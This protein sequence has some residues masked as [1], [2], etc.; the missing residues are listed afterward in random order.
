MHKLYYINIRIVHILHEPIKAIRC[1]LIFFAKDE[2]PP[3]LRCYNITVRAPDDSDELPVDYNVTCVDVVDS[4]PTLTCNRTNGSVFSVGEQVV[5]CW[6]QDDSGNEDH[7]SFTVT[8]VG[9][10][11]VMYYKLTKW[12][13]DH[14][15]HY[16]LIQWTV[17]SLSLVSIC[18]M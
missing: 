12:I 7:C 14:V 1:I 17:R 16:K 18:I 10:Y 2:T 5:E 9:R 6:C 8:V 11:H 15:M 3:D 13:I 4:S